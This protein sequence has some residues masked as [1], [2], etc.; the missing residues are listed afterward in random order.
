MEQRA[1]NVHTVQSQTVFMECLVNTVLHW[2]SSTKLSYGSLFVGNVEYEC[3]KEL[4]HCCTATLYH[5]YP[6]AY[7]GRIDFNGLHSHGKL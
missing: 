7:S 1:R 4:L 3:V 2:L 6:D 5:N